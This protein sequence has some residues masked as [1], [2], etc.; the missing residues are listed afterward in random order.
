MR[1]IVG[2]REDDPE[3]QVAAEE[4]R[5]RALADVAG[6]REREAGRAHEVVHRPG[7][8]EHR[9]VV[10]HDRGDD[11]VGAGARFQVAGNESIRR[12]T[13]RTREHRERHRDDRRRGRERRARHR[14]G[15]G[16]DEELTGDAD[17]EEAGLE[18]ETDREAAEHQRR[19]GDKRVGDRAAAAERTREKARVRGEGAGADRSPFS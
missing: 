6:A 14:R 16:A 13:D 10:E 19:G 12:A 11:L 1:K 17:V 3:M 15:E 8:Q 18:A 7:E 5:Q 2:D 9:R 4:D